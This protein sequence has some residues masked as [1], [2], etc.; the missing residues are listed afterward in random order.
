MLRSSIFTLIASLSLV[1]SVVAGEFWVKW[2]DSE[3]A[4]NSFDTSFSYFNGPMN[5][6]KN[7]TV[8]NKKGLKLA[9]VYADKEGNVWQWVNATSGSGTY[10]IQ[11]DPQWAG[12]RIT[13]GEELSIELRAYLKNGTIKT[14]KTKKSLKITK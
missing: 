8:F 10:M 6:E 12:R 4:V 3:A 1:T 2:D 5:T 9:D 14:V 11:S 7:G 13:A